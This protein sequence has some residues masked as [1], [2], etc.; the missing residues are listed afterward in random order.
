MKQEEEI[1]LLFYTND[2]KKA[3]FVECKWRNQ[4]VGMDV[5]SDLMRKSELLNQFDEKHYALCSKSGFKQEVVEYAKENK[6]VWL[7]DLDEI[8]AE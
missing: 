6:N 1:D 2:N 5:L 4:K 7:Y 8:L 3:C